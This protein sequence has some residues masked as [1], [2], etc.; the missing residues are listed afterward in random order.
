[1]K[2]SNSRQVEAQSKPPSLSQIADDVYPTN[3]LN[4]N[5]MGEELLQEYSYAD[6]VVE[7]WDLKGDHVIQIENLPLD[8]NISSLTEFVSS[9][10]DVVDCVMKEV[11][12]H[13][14]AQIK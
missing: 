11:G 9:F 2:Q 4:D 1:M 10:G 8:V 7:S 5:E 12:N 13:K 3:Q 6:A 14:V